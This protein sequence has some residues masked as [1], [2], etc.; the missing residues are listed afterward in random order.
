[1]NPLIS[2]PNGPLVVSTVPSYKADGIPLQLSLIFP[3]Y[4]ESQNIKELIDQVCSVLD[5]VLP[6][7]YELIIVDDNS[8]DQTWLVAQQLSQY[9]PQLQVMRRVDERGLATA[10]IRGWQVGQG[11]VLGVMD[12]DLQHPPEVLEGLLQACITGADLAV[13]SRHVEGGGVSRWSLARRITSRGA[14]LIG[15]VLLPEVVG[16]VSDPMSGYFFVQRKAIADIKL[17]PLGY[18]ILLEVLG[19]GMVER[20]QEVGYVFQERQQG[21][22]KVTPRQ[23]WEYLGHL[24]QLR[25]DR[26]PVRRFLTFGLVGLSGVV[27]DNFFLYLLS[28][29]HTLGWGLTRSKIIAAELA[30]INNFWWNDRWTFGDLA[31]EQNKA[32]QRGLRFLKFNA[33]CAIGLGFNVLLLNFFFNTFHLNRY[34]ANL[35]AIAIVTVWN[36]WINLKLSWRSS[37]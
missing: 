25:L 20:V 35:L 16:R 13:A 17:N 10:V 12:A 30:I 14:Q 8:P 27:I 24:L 9:Y 31:A 15:L 6:G 18:K 22:S 1:M 34:L 32:T 28:D 11:Q 2:P 33:V 36:F 7:A 4:Q 23:Y 21:T 19:R 37:G 5:K 3:T 26:L 29:P